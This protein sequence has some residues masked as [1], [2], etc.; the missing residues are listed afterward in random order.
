MEGELLYPSVT[1]LYIHE[2]I[3]LII[4]FGKNLASYTELYLEEKTEREKVAYDASSTTP[5]SG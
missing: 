2:F 3:E 5:G 1:P 4:F